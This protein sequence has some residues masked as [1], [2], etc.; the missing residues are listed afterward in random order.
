M[1]NFLLCCFYFIFFI[2]VINLMQILSFFIFKKIY[3]V[4]FNLIE[5]E[6]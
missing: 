6:S 1:K 5:I 4:K 2:K 3:E